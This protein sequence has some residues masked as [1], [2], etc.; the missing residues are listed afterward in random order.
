MTSPDSVLLCVAAERDLP[1]LR[2]VLA[3]LPADQYGQVYVETASETVHAIP[4]PERMAVSWLLRRDGEEVGAR[5]AV[6]VRTWS[7]EWMHDAGHDSLMPRLVW[8]GRSVRAVA[9]GALPRCGCG[10]EHPESHEAA[11]SGEGDAR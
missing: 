3:D 6:A 11:L 2:A 5:A 10:G 7:A 1:A 4:A 8:I 9:G